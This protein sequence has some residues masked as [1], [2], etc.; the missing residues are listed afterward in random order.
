MLY[1]GSKSSDSAY[2]G[3]LLSGGSK[4]LN[5]DHSKAVCNTDAAAKTLDV[6][7]T[8][9]TEN[10]IPKGAATTKDADITGP[11]YSGKLVYLINGAGAQDGVVVYNKI[12]SGELKKEDIQVE[13]FQY[14]TPDG[15]ADPL[16]LN[17]GTT[18][19]VIFKNSNDAD[20]IAGCKMFI[21]EF[22]KNPVYADEL[23]KGVGI[24]P[25]TNTTIDYGDEYINGQVKFANECNVKYSTDEMGIQEPWRPQVRESFYTEMQALLVGQKTSRQALDSFVSKVNTIIAKETKK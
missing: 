3:F 25:V 7:N 5:D 14:P 8:L 22:V 24:A 23:A 2:Y 19:H 9:S 6:L 13:F 10:L 15:K 17:W 16:S 20:K 21:E 1:A 18:G 4:I 11:F 12:K